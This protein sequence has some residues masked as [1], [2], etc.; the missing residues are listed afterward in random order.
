MAS[1]AT[2][3]PPPPSHH[4]PVGRIILAVIGA[5]LVVLALGLGAAGTATTLAYAG[6]RDAAGYL[7][8]GTGRLETTSHAITSADIALER[9]PN[10]R[11]RAGADLDSFTAV[12]LTIESRTAS[13]VFVGIGRTADVDAYL[14]HVAHAEITDLDLDARPFAV[15]YRHVPGS[16][17][18]QPPGAQAFWAAR[19][20]GTGTR[21]LDWQPERGRWTVVIM[22]T[23]GSAGVAVDGSAGIK[24][25]WLLP[26]GI[27]LLTAAGVLL[28]AGT[29]LLVVGI[30]GLHHHLDAAPVGVPGP[31]PLRIEGDLDPDLSRWLW[32]VKWILAIPHLVVLAVL[33]S[34]F[35]V[36]TVVAGIAVLVTGRYPRP[37]FDFNVGVLRWSWRVGFYC[38]AAFGT[39][40]Y[41]PFTL[42]P[43]PDYPASLDLA[44]PERLSRGLVLV[45]WWLLAIPHYVVV[46]II[47][48]GSTVAW[49]ADHGR[50]TVNSPGLLSWLLV[51][52]VVVLLFTGRYPRALFDLVMG[53]NR[54]ALRVIAYVALMTD[55][56]PPFRLDQGAHE[57]DLRPAPGD[58]DGTVSSAPRHNR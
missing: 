25:D 17:P 47:G 48:G 53:L 41:P 24:A 21:T 3:G 46:A 29:V 40:H 30:V 20:E 56:Y 4:V 16:A 33:W 51:V 45:K 36:L 52:A 37:L 49:T 26:V 31:Y 35:A 6:G 23:D 14:D 55:D 44:Y 28:V 7:T 15:G 42:G 58:A 18:S 8:S 12:R 34:V 1:T 5:L 50:V 2:P 39:D 43:A 27:G 13:P 38:F 57:P 9:M 11:R 32:L 19:T 10:L 22:N 54:W